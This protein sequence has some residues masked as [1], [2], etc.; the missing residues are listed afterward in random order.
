M[1]YLTIVPEEHAAAFGA[2]EPTLEQ[3]AEEI[4]KLRGDAAAIRV[5][6]SENVRTGVYF[7]RC[8]VFKEKLAAAA[9]AI[10]MALL[11]QIRESVR[12]SNLKLTATFQETTVKVAEVPETGEDALNLKKFIQNAII[13]ME[14]MKEQI[15]KNKDKEIFLTSYRWVQGK[16]GRCRKNLN[17]FSC[18]FAQRR[19]QRYWE[20]RGLELQSRNGLKIKH[21]ARIISP[22]CRCC[23]THCGGLL[24]PSPGYARS[25]RV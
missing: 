11:D 25:T 5:T 21:D 4:D 12:D 1:K 2:D 23:L 22:V 8:S 14:K 10:A 19:L 7:V 3:Y 20:R 9:E 13:S 16:R 18:I 6:C 24:L 17:A 15:A